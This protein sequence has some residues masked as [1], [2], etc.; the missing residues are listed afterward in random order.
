MN[1]KDAFPTLGD[2][3]RPPAAEY[4]E[5]ILEPCDFWQGRSGKSHHKFGL[6]LR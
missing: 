5:T 2:D 6:D 3:P 1:E 4:L